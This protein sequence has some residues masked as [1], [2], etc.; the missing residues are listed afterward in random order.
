[1]AAIRS[2][3]KIK[4][5]AAKTPIGVNFNEL[6]KGINR[7]GTTV[8]SIG[9]NLEQ[10]RKLI[11]F[12][13]QF[14]R[15]KGTKEI[16]NVKA[17]VKQKETFASK[18]KR[19][20]KQLFQRKKRDD[21]ERIAEEGLD[22]G[23]KESKKTV[24][25]VKKPVKGFLEAI[26]SILGTVVKYF[27]TFAVL[28]VMEKNPEAFVKVFKLAWTIGKF[29]FNLAKFGIAGIMDGLTNMFGDFSD[30]N[31]G[32]VKRGLRFILGAFQVLGGFA[33]LRAATYILKPWKLMQDINW[34]RGVFR[35]SK[36]AG[37]DPNA[38]PPRGVR[39]SNASK[40]ARQRYAR[41]YGGRAAKNR[42]ASRVP[43][44]QAFKGST[45]MGRMGR[46]AMS[47]KGM[48]ALSVLGGGMR[49]ASGLQSG[50]GAGTAVGAGV[51]QAVGGIAGAA[52]LTAVAPW[53]GPL[54][55][56][57]GS[58]VGSF[59]G[60]WVGKSIG[61]IIEPIMG[62]IGEYFKM[63]FDIIKDVGAE[64]LKPFQEMFGALFDFLGPLFGLIGEGLK[65]LG[66]FTKF[67]L[68]GAINVIGKTVQFIISNA[69]RLM[70]P[71]SV[72]AGI[73]DYMTFGLT[74]FDGMGRAGGGMVGTP[75]PSSHP[76]S[77][78]DDFKALLL[79]IVTNKD[80]KSLR[81]ILI[82]GVQIIEKIM[83]IKAT[84]QAN[85]AAQPGS[86]PGSPSSS[87]SGGGFTGSG[88]ATYGSDNAKALLNAIADAEGT[89]QYPNSGYNTQFTGSQFTGIK[90]PR[91]IKGNSGLRSDAAGRY[92]FLSTTWDSAAGRDA[93]MTP[94]NQDR[95]ALKLV[96]GR[97]VNIDNGL[98]LNEIYRL[99]GEWASIEGGPN[100]KKGGGYGGQAKY[101]A[102][103][104]LEMYKKYG[105]T[106]E[107]AMGGKLADH[108]K[109][110]DIKKETPP[111]GF[112]QREGKSIIAPMLGKGRNLPKYAEGGSHRTIPDT[113]S[114]S[115]AAGIPLTRVYASTGQNAEVALP[116][117]KRFQGFIKDL[118]GTG[119][120]IKEMGGF[121]PDGPPA[122]NVDGKGPQ[123]AH[124]YGAAIDINWTKNPAF[125]GKTRGDFPANSAELAGKH[126]L[127]W[128]SF[129]D[130]AM[131]FSAMKRERGAGID[132]K[133]I[134]G[135]A[136]RNA[137]GSD[138]VPSPTSSSGSSSS[139]SSS[140][141]GGA[142]VSDAEI[143]D[144]NL[145]L[146]QKI[147]K[148]FSAFETGFKKAF[149]STKD[150]NDFGNIGKTEAEL[151]GNS[152][153]VPKK[154]SNTT[155]QQILADAL[156]AGSQSDLQN[157]IQDA[158]RK[159]AQREKDREMTIPQPSVVQTTAVQPV[160]NN[161]GGGGKQVVYATPSPMVSP[162]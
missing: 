31:E 111:P 156:P 57:I 17:E 137:S 79:E 13:R 20:G 27:I 119:Y 129:F 51:G 84:K 86:T 141:S 16:Q 148:I 134:T 149:G 143:N 9:V 28:D 97:G 136:L 109:Q 11:E 10:A 145:T 42:F 3:V 91:E 47:M 126:G 76:R 146:D 15:E 138:Y 132:G 54:A 49:I 38:R 72:G 6:R 139:S 124:P 110:Q 158:S 112:K 81:G 1:M 43:G 19:L 58:A 18:V 142:T 114:T 70:N 131:H 73:L 133:E 71:A 45:T 154:I 67:V 160:I 121:R 87:P 116:L 155:Q 118:E 135:D 93:D 30:L 98:S 22:E 44:R 104:F 147:E 68:G 162:H 8:Q 34:V 4:P 80:D 59:L 89:S 151:R 52:A 99:G 103:Q 5:T 120:K 83:G 61:P 102:E 55:P 75:P 128:G 32:K 37:V 41:R 85:G 40:E 53:L 82:K 123:Y 96:S 39:S 127:G 105:G 106:P 95:A 23:K 94:E 101:T 14:L 113:P 29:A 48:G 130:D 144:D 108:K 12:E 64:L 74:D 65:I 153:A 122:G 100:M 63:I 25:K 152:A 117:A 159:K 36:Q 2:F 60:E 140:S 77:K 7:T 161:A 21:S 92:Q 62:P 157:S 46:S 35:G 50:E 88:A 24:E 125:V 56:M 33:A 26:G 90:H 69:K 66:D 107:M 150:L 115:W 78:I